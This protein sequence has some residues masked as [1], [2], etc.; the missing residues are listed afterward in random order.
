M[1]NLKLTIDKKGVC[2]LSIQ[3]DGIPKCDGIKCDQNMSQS[4]DHA[5]KFIL[6]Y[7]IVDSGLILIQ[8]IVYG[9]LFIRFY[10]IMSMRCI[11]IFNT[12]LYIFLTIL[13]KISRKFIQ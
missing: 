13:V 8:I 7:N 9:T 12:H 5:R 2:L 10:N 3:L 4:G 1:N 6:L 11:L